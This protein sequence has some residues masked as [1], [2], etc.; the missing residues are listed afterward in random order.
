MVIMELPFDV[1]RVR[2]TAPA[3]TITLVAGGPVHTVLHMRAKHH[4]ALKTARAGKGDPVAVIFD[5]VKEVVPTMTDD[6]HGNLTMEEARAI[7]EISASG[8]AAVEDTIPN[9]N[10]PVTPTSPA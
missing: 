9:A 1:S 3:G 4:H 6:E 2:K 8:I 10:G 7:L 5:M